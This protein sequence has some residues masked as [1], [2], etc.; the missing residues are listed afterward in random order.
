MF[1]FLVSP[2]SFCHL[3]Q[4]KDVDPVP[5]A[6]LLKMPSDLSTSFSFGPIESYGFWELLICL[7]I[8]V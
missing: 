2:I 7:L 5:L 1:V 3:N 4:N 8:N 6:H